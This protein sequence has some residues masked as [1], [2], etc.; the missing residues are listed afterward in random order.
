M[1]VLALASNDN[2]NVNFLIKNETVK[3]WQCNC[4]RT[5]TKMKWGDRPTQLA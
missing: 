4:N 3:S 2:E 5:D 1:L